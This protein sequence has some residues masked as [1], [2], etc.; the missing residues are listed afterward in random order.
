MKPLLP[1]SKVKVS[2]IPIPKRSYSCLTVRSIFL[3]AMFDRA[4]YC[5]A[6]AWYLHYTTELRYWTTVVHIYMVKA[7]SPPVT[8]TTPTSPLTPTRPPLLTYYY[9]YSSPYLPL[10]LFFTL[11][12]ITPTPPLVVGKGNS[13]GSKGR[14]WCISR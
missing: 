1:Q 8:T 7:V 6:P 4:T 11:P 13:R 10:P 5:D 2:L 3:N 12:T 14:S 9:P